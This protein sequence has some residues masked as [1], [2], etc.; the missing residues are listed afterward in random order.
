MAPALALGSWSWNW[1]QLNS[2]SP[3]M[4]IARP[5]W[6]SM[7]ET[8]T[9]VPRVELQVALLPRNRGWIQQTMGAPWAHKMLT[10]CDEVFIGWATAALYRVSRAP[11]H[12]ASRNRMGRPP[13][14]FEQLL[15][16][17]WRLERWTAVDM[18]PIQFSGS[19]DRSG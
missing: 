4:H 6:C 5:D 7:S 14:T 1:S 11:R 9:E 16:G 3:A 18:H 2:V 15:V 19:V 17:T 8:Q 12:V 13:R 10:Q